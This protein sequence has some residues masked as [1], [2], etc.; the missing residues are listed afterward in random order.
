MLW[1]FTEKWCVDASVPRLGSSGEVK[2][3]KAIVGGLTQVLSEAVEP[4]PIGAR[5][6]DSEDIIEGMRLSERLGILH[7][8]LW[9]VFEDGQGKIRTNAMIDMVAFTVAQHRS[10][11]VMGSESIKRGEWDWLAN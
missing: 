5:L 4:I 9:L 10:F 6:M 11:A 2:H 7:Y 8:M 3:F 1:L